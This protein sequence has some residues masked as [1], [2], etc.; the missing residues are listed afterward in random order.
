MRHHVLK[1]SRDIYRRLEKDGWTVRSVSGSHH[2]FKK[3]GER[4][5]ITLPHPRKD[6]PPG[7]VRN[8]YKTAGWPKD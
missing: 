6:L 7:L 1:N 5:N 2:V 8:I 3:P 4:D